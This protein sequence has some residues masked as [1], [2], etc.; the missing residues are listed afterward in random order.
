[1]YS[2]KLVAGATMPEMTVSLASGEEVKIGGGSDAGRWQ[3]VIVFRGLHCPL[4]VNYL[5]VLQGL[6]G[7]FDA[8]DTDIIAI[9]GDGIEKTK[10]MEEKSEVSM[11]LAYGLT[12]EQMKELGLYISDPRSPQETDQPFPEPGLFVV[13]PDGTIQIIDISNAPFSRP[14]LNA[15]LR[16]VM[17]G[18]EKGYPIRGTHVA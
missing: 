12:V 16:G 15:I 11:R 17:F 7:D 5:K 8:Q 9:S 6:A 10:L 1:L 4:C 14:D 2:N 3:L 13:R 18:R